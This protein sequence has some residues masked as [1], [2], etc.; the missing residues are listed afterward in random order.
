MNKN[1]GIS[2][3]T[4]EMELFLNLLKKG[5]NKAKINPKITA[6]SIFAGLSDF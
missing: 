5:I 6:I 4:N 2:G 3:Y 1:N